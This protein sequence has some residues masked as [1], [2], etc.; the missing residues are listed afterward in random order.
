MSTVALLQ[1]R[2]SPAAA[3]IEAALGGH[4]CRCGTQQRIRAAVLRAAQLM[5]GEP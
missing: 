2:P 3:D 5:R 1:A 4:L